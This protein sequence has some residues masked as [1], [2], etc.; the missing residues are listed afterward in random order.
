M[1]T[2]SNAFLVAEEVDGDASSRVVGCV[3]VSWSGVAESNDKDVD[4]HFGMLCVQDEYAGRGIG[5]LL[6]SAAGTCA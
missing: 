3:H 4:A 1:A 6:V 5:K 2:P